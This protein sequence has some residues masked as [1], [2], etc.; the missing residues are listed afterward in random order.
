M[1]EYLIPNTIRILVLVTAVIAT[2]KWNKY[3]LSSE[4]FFLL[5]LWVTVI[6]ELIATVL[7]YLDIDAYLI[8]NIYSIFS[9]LFYLNWFYALLK[10]KLIKYLSLIFIII[11]VI[12]VFFQNALANHLEFT[13][14][15]GAISILICT[16]MYYSNALKE[17][18]VYILKQKLSFWIVTGILF[19]HIGMVPLIFL[20]DLLEFSGVYYLSILLCLNIILYGCY[21][22]GFLWTKKT[23]NR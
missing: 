2:L 5:F 16:F 12:N 3:N 13:F 18:E 20:T 23:F 8:Y 15:F 21:I 22:I 11:A 6:I 14:F 17:D 9:F 1:N 7:N 4:R 19:F 10:H